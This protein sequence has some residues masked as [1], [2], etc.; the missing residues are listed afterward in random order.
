M[1]KRYR[2]AAG[3]TQGELAER[4]GYS[5]GHVSKLESSVRQPVPATVEL[6]ADALDL[7]PAERTALGR[8]TRR[9][10]AISHGLPNLRARP[11]PPLTGRR[12]EEAR[13]ERH[14]VAEAEPPLLLLAGE[15]GI[16]KSRLLEIG[17]A[18]V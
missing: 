10:D 15:P 16:G 12:G 17:R 1:L 4:A 8:A 13:I 14:L 7:A 11:L 6:L 3:L 2:R 18:H 9:N 5:V